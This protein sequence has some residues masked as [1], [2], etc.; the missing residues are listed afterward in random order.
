M[1]KKWL[2]V[3]LAC[4]SFAIHAS[5]VELNT[6]TQADLEALKGIGPVKSKAII[7]ERAKNGP[8]KDADDF[9]TRVKGIGDKTVVSLESQGLTINGSTAA[10]KGTPSA[11]ASSKKTTGANVKSTPAATATAAAS[12]PAAAAATASAT[13]SASS[14]SGKKSKKASKKAG[15][16]A[17]SAAS[18][19]K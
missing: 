2:L 13:D 18:A 5:A 6:A 16:S 11:P 10:P 9:A 7:D 12:T 4:L 14:A 8:F 3:L 19:S 17:A 1:M 15:A